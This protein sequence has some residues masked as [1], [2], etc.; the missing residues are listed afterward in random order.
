M[1]LISSIIIDNCRYSWVW[2]VV[3]VVWCG[4]G[5][6]RLLGLATLVCRGRVEIVL[7][8]RTGGLIG[9]CVNSGSAVLLSKCLV[10]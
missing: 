1:V 10:W 2:F 6:V 4:C 8:N 7:K 3:G 9:S 5:A